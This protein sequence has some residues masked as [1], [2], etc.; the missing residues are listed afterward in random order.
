MSCQRHGIL[1]L[2]KAGSG[3]LAEGPRKLTIS[4]VLLSGMI[5]LISSHQAQAGAC[6]DG[7]INPTSAYNYSCNDYVLN[8]SFLLDHVK[9][10]MSALY[11]LFG[12]NA[13]FVRLSLP[14][15]MLNYG[16]NQ[17]VAD[18]PGARQIG[19]TIGTDKRSNYGIW[20][21]SR[22]SYYDMTDSDLKGDV[23]GA[24]SIFGFDGRLGEGGVWGAGL[25]Y[26]HSSGEQDP[27]AL[28]YRVKSRTNGMMALVRGGYWIDETLS[29]NARIAY[30]H[31]WN[32]RATPVFKDE[33]KTD[34]LGVGLSINGFHQL[35][36]KH[37]LEGA[38]GW[39]GT[40]THRA[41]STDSSN[42]VHGSHTTHFGEATVTGRLLRS[43]AAQ[44]AVAFVDAGLSLVTEDDSLANLDD[45]PFS[46]EIGLGLAARLNERASVQARLF[47]G[48][49]GQESREVVGGTA[50]FVF[51]F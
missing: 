13:F 50:S 14:S 47:V 48:G 19:S 9:I 27:T 49:L 2:R 24:S 1:K 45:E 4:A 26:F 32:K 37:W 20:N 8:A 17:S 15:Q 5:G 6:K 39:A 51:G 35:D 29:I 41:A 44:K 10:P 16:P 28:G 3:A 34:M 36:K 42:I 38:L 22:L 11:S 7:L 18:A 33:Y 21:Q 46:G 23:T 12:S 31:G 30:A 43:F 25:G 40:W